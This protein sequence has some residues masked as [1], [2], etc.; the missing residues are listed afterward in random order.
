MYS[1]KPGAWAVGG[2]AWTHGRLFR[3][4]VISFRGVLGTRKT[5]RKDNV[6]GW[7]F[8]FFSLFL[9]VLISRQ[10]SILLIGWG[11]LK[12]ARRFNE[13]LTNLQQCKYDEWLMLDSDTETLMAIFSFSDWL[14]APA[15]IDCNVVQLR[16]T[17][18]SWY[19]EKKNQWPN[20]EV[21]VN[22]SFVSFEWWVSFNAKD[23]WSLVCSAVNFWSV[24]QLLF[25]SDIGR[26]L[27]PHR[28]NV[29]APFV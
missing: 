25:I 14:F 15:M 12:F 26:A 9:I 20:P 7:L 28:R 6:C 3:R 13:A 19:C 17:F 22:F 18:S 4:F 29:P 11:C 16:A 5:R 10:A 27:S 1:S 23:K 2:G 8:F 21:G 24:E